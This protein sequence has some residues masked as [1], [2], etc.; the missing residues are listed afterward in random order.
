M[1]RWDNEEKLLRIKGRYGPNIVT[2]LTN[3]YLTEKLRNETSFENPQALAFGAILFKH[4]VLQ[5]LNVFKSEI[6]SYSTVCP[7]WSYRKRQS[8]FTGKDVIVFE[9]PLLRTQLKLKPT[10]TDNQL[11][12]FIQLRERIRNPEKKPTDYELLPTTTCEIK[13]LLVE[14]LKTGKITPKPPLGQYLLAK[15]IK[16]HFKTISSEY[17][18]QLRVSVEQREKKERLIISGEL[19]EIGIERI[20]D[21]FDEFLLHL[22]EYLSGIRI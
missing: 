15:Q 10:R 1:I 13:L 6:K 22:G 12:L 4:Q 9:R 11:K 21:F 14:K 17:P 7:T 20:I 3:D 18:L 8:R 5:I 19:R 16:D 2:H